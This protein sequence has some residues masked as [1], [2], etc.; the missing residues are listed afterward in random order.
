MMRRD[1]LTMMCWPMLGSRYK[2]ETCSRERQM[3]RDK[4]KPGEKP[5]SRA[6]KEKMILNTHYTTELFNHI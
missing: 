3:D 5:L 2:C 1:R 4:I 6:E